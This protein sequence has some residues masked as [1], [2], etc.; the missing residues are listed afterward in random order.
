MERHATVVRFLDHLKVAKNYS[1]H[2]L[3]A[4]ERELDRLGNFNPDP[5][6]L[7]T[8]DL[9][10]FMGT[11]HD[12]GLTAK[13]IQRALSAIRSYY[14]F[15]FSRGEIINN[16]AN[17]VQAPKANRKLPNLLDTDQAAALFKDS[18]STPREQRD[19]AILELFYGAGL[20]LAE[21]VGL[22][23]KDVDLDTGTA[24][25]V[26]KGN[27]VRMAPLGRM[28]VKAIRAWLAV[29]PYPMPNAA[30]FTGRGPNRISP[31]TVQKR[32][33]TLA[34]QRLGNDTLHP[35]ML[36][37]SFASHLLE[38][39]GDLRAIQELLGHSD[40]AT[41]QIYTHLDFQHLARVYDQAHPRA[42][43]AKTNK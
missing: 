15:L 27:K 13:S 36:R 25:V 26:G 1:P 23:I 5:T 14:Q 3:K 21:L 8:H 32:L 39:S 35:H 42:Q 38:S 40:I 10:L 12:A 41:T 18:G 9:T 22:D 28:C 31:R 6:Q 16:P 33:K 19:Q 29:H 2:T 37:H 4:Y 20:R 11:L 24:T 7:K 17:A 43:R 34:Q 30:L